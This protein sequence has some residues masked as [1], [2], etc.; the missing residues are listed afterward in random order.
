MAKTDEKNET[1]N[2]NSDSKTLKY[3][4]C[5]A[6]YLDMF[7]KELDKA[8]GQL[9]FRGQANSEWE[10]A[11]SAARRLNDFKLEG[12]ENATSQSDF[13]SYHVNMI[14]NARSYGYGE[15]TANSK[16]SD[17]EILAEIQHYG[18]STCLV[19]F[20]TN[21]LIAL[22]MATEKNV[23]S[24][25][26]FENC[27]KENCEID[28][29]QDKKIV[30]VKKIKD[31]TRL[32]YQKEDKYKFQIV[33]NNEEN[34]GKIFW[35]DLGD[36]NNLQNIVY[37]NQPKEGDTIQKLLAK[38]QWN[39]ELSQ[40]K[41]EP[42]FWLWNP[43]K[44][45]E[46]IIRQDSVFIF[47]LAAFP[48][49][50]QNAESKTTIDNKNARIAYH[51]IT[52]DN[53][54]KE[55]VRNELET[56]FGISAE[57]VFYDLN[58]FA[59][60]ANHSSK[61]IS[62]KIMPQANC[63]L[64]A[65]EYIKKE[66]FS[67]AIKSL[68]KALSCKQKKHDIENNEEKNETDKCS[69]GLGGICENDCL[70]ELY[71]WKGVALEGRKSE[72]EALLNYH[73]S[74]DSFNQPEFAYFDK[75]YS[76]L[77][78]AYRNITDILYD[79]K[80]YNGAEQIQ[81]QLY[82]HYSINKD[83]FKEENPNYLNGA[84]AVLSLFELRIMQF[85]NRNGINHELESIQ[86]NDKGTNLIDIAN[87]DLRNKTNSAIVYKALDTLDMLISEQEDI[88]DTNVKTFY[89][90]ID[91]ILN[92]IYNEIE[93][94]KKRKERG[95]KLEITLISYFWWEFKDIIT[96]IEDIR[97]HTEEKDDAKKIFI[98]NNA[99]KL[100]LIAQKARDAQANRLLN[101]IFEVSKATSMDKN[102]K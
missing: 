79:K 66:Q 34:D 33:Y 98:K 25:P 35:I 83:F 24:S 14:A 96:W 9:I 56:L 21:F 49:V 59:Y 11:S 23:T 50:A 64:M 84:E 72:D 90:E 46:R 86:I 5:V 27:N 87:T 36:E 57:T 99:A 101:K 31:K 2:G 76:I 19:D 58:G 41:M 68:N 93:E 26:N 15:L 89:S 71:F 1:K 37:Y 13:I 77:C 61:P 45:N 62:K 16:L 91:D 94:N 81:N 20:S 12:N 102:E 3:T 22:W 32:E 10:L 69:R 39:F 73:Y 85:K 38:N 48:T 54:D 82:K 53:E 40:H 17:L 63:L 92:G 42:C 97:D 4:S 29:S 43:T 88:T 52:I 74:I 78:E 28:K 51:E 80:D 65:R 67:Q 18:G 47:G 60:D 6:K 100:I 70:G 95:E 44:L 30:K 7:Y 75:K 55:V 8:K